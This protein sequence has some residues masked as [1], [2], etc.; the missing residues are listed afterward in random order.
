MPDLT[1]EYHYW[2]KS[3]EFWQRKVVGSKG[4]EYTVLYSKAPRNSKY[5]YDYSCNCHAFQFG[6]GKFCKHIHQV[7]SERCGWNWEAACGSSAIRPANKKCPKCGGELL[8]I[9][10][11]V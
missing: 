9:K 8:V 5:E 6:K 4:S 11:G 3:N 7:K 1:I 2:C 10:V